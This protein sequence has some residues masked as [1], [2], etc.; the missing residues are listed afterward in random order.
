VNQTVRLPRWRSAASYA[1][2]FVTLY[3]CFGM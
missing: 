2:Q 3:R 1:A